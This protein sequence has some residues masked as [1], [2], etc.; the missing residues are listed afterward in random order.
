MFL[1]CGVKVST[2]LK[3]SLG[4][5]TTEMAKFFWLDRL[6]MEILEKNQLVRLAKL[7]YSSDWR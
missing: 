6:S 4:Q 5:V 2:H 7:N 1:M 3:S